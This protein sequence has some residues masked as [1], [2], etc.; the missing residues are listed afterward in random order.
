VVAAEAFAAE[1]LR[2]ASR[3]Y[4]ASPVRT[5]IYVDSVYRKLDGTVYGELAFTN[6]LAG[7]ADEMQVTIIGRLDSGNGAACYPIRDEIRFV[8]LPH[9]ESLSNLRAALTPLLSSLRRFWDTVGDADTVWLFGPYLL[10]Q[11]FTVLALIRGRRVVLGVRQDFPTYVRRRRPT[12][13]WMHLAANILERGW[14]IWAKWLPTVVVGPQLADN[15]R[16]SRSLLQITVSL[17]R[18]EDIV[19]EGCARARSYDGDLQVLSVGRL[20]EEKNPL[21]LADALALLRAQ[22]P[23]WRLVICGDGSLR[24]QLIE[25]LDAL[26]VRDAT[27]LRGHLPLHNGLLRLYRSSHVFLHVSR[28]EGFPQVLIEAFASGVPVVATAVGGVPGGVADAAILVEPE[29]ARAAAEAVSRVAADPA[30]RQRLIT[31]GFSKA[32]EHTM[33]LEIQRVTDFMRG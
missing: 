24:G 31:A 7:M 6:F 1:A 10:S 23:R 26:G 16:H 12:L 25:R 4:D 29:D 11:L 2:R 19:D 27:E 20:D 8:A 21:L 32:R 14:R 33:E 18:R 15:Y 3:R 5:L 28:T 13:R 9:Y 22:D 17:I 30:L